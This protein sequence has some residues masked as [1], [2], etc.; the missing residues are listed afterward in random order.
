MLENSRIL[1][2]TKDAVHW[3]EAKRFG[4]AQPRTDRKQVPI[5]RFSKVR[6]EKEIVMTEAGIQISSVRPYLQTPEGVRE[7]FRKVSQMGYRVIQLQWISPDVPAGFIRDALMETRL[8][9]VGTQDYSDE[10]LPRLQEIVRM[11]DLW[12]GKYICVSGIPERFQSCEGCAAF[13]AELNRAAKRLEAAGK[14][15]AFHPRS[16]E[17]VK[18]GGRTALDILLEN[19]ESPFQVELDVYHVQKAGYDPVDWIHRL[20]GRMDL[21]HFKDTAAAPDGKQ[22]LTPVGEGTLDWQGI[23]EACGRTGVRYAFAEQESWQGDPFD[24]LQRSYRFM[25]AHG[26]R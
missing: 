23:F 20:K 6:K 14:I 18:Y 4:L 13:A 16:Q 7:S 15:L 8:H 12:G 22:I 10:V 5:G 11:N 24:C 25:A 9:C 2:Y 17:F 26:I 1:E 3:I 19:T 21:I